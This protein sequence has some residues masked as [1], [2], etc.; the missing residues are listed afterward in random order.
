MTEIPKY[1]RTAIIGIA[2]NTV[3]ALGVGSIPL[4]DRGGP[5]LD[6]DWL[7]GLGLIGILLIP[8]V[9][10]AVGLRWPGALLPAGVVSI[11]MCL[12]SFSF[13]LFPLLIPAMLYLVAYGDAQVTYKARV[14]APLVAALT[15]ALLFGAFF[16]LFLHD[17][18]YCYEIVQRKDG[19]TF[20]RE[21]ASSA[22]QGG[23][24]FGHESLGHGGGRQV[25]GSGCSSDSVTGT[26][27]ATSLGLVLIA[28]V[29]AAFLSAP[30]K[31]RLLV[32][33]G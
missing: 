15:V 5:S 33:G 3:I 8:P 11:P 2:I 1:R 7:R 30:R 18:P 25:I 6:E 29:S 23:T 12:M 17:D 19:S 22:R 28:G 10:A 14:P 21:V 32:G 24:S 13:I 31:K 4:L 16:S 9:L 27:A 26:E 20:E